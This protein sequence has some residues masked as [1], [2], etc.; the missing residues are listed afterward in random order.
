MR[1]I[2]TDNMK[3]ANSNYNKF[4]MYYMHWFYDNLEL[5]SQ[6]HCISEKKRHTFH[7]CGKLS[8]RSSN[9]ANSWQKHISRNLKQTYTHSPQKLILYDCIIPCKN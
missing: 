2:P 6:Y 8:Q 5:N 3:Y 4:P 1:N 9:S 7:I